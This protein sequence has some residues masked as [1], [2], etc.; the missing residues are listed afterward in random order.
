MGYFP[1]P[2]RPHNFSSLFACGYRRHTSRIKREEAFTLVIVKYPPVDPLGTKNLASRW[3]SSRRT[4][5]ELRKASNTGPEH[6]SPSLH[7]FLSPFLPVREGEEHGR[8]KEGR[9][10]KEKD[11]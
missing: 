2:C 1:K 10:G 4:R 3:M 5:R 9:K 11:K 6:G 8:R 7:L